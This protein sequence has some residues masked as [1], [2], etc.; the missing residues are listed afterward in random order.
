[1]ACQRYNFNLTAGDSI[2]TYLNCYNS[3]GSFINLSGYSLTGVVKNNFGDTG[4]IYNLNP[5]IAAWSGVIM[6]SGSS[7]STQ[8]L[9]PGS[10]SYD[11]QIFNN[12]GYSLKVLNGDFNLF[13]SS[14]Y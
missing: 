12:Q 11:I 1:M 8:S 4:Y 2:L 10:Y 5:Q 6:V 7:V 9:I 14:N 13:P 3:D